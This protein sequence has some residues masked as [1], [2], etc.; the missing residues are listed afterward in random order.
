MQ[1]WNEQ[2]KNDEL[3]PKQ[4]YNAFSKN[5]TKIMQLWNL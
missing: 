4:R 2:M 1:N 3:V 5:K